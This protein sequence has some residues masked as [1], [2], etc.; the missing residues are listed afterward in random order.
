[1]KITNIE[2]IVSSPARNFV[3]VKVETDEGIYGLGDATLNGR[4]LAVVSCLEDHVIPCVIGRDPFDTEDIWQYL[5][6]GVYWRRGPINMTAIGAIDM[7]LWDIKGKALGVPVYKLLGGKCRDRLMVYTHAQGRDTDETLEEIDKAIHRGFKAIRV[8]C[9]IPGLEGVYGVAK[10]QG[11]YEPASRGDLPVEER[12]ST[13][14]YLNFLPGLFA[15][16]RE[17]FGDDVHLLHDAHHRL[18]PIEA[19]RLGKAL[20]PYHLFW[21]EDAVPA[22]LQEGF[23]VIRKHTTT[24]L[25]VGEVF[26]TIHD[27]H[28]LIT[29][30]LIDYIRLAVAHGGG[31]TPMMKIAS[32]ADLYHVKTGCHGPS[33]LSPVNL[34]ACLHF[35]MAI[36]NYGV[37]EYMGYADLTMEV[38]QLSH[39]FA[40]GHFLMSESP[41]LGVEMDFEKAKNHPYERAYLPINRLEDGTLHNY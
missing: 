30:Q 8:Q 31:I 34:A 39:E 11:A 5:Y 41:G 4:E 19:A 18:T 27:C 16:V 21:L 13:E 10:E 6:R 33:D 35:G 37:Q 9:G 38:F 12:W 3:T 29:H 26:N 2:V 28:H 20:E 23:E 32:L 40:D 15:Q 22:E 14:K 1:M 24:P 7:A 17:R 25:A 36:H